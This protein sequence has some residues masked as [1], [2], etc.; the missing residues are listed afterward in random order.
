MV[1][2]KYMHAPRER[3][4]M[5]QLLESNKLNSLYNQSSHCQLGM[6]VLGAPS[7]IMQL[8]QNFVFMWH[9]MNTGSNW[10]LKTNSKL[11][12][13]LES[14]LWVLIPLSNTA[15]NIEQ[16]KTLLCLCF[17]KPRGA[18][19]EEKKRS[20]AWLHFMIT[21][22]DDDTTILVSVCKIILSGQTEQAILRMW[23][24]N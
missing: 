20:R 14:H 18:M 10:W 15:Q 8:Y 24:L 21:D 19:A 6:R 4:L 1:V 12:E 22:D 16:R 5:R 17:W 9:S 2:N 7:N 13:M 3:R 23:A 11:S